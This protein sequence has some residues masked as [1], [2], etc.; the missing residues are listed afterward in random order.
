VIATLKPGVD[1]DR[2]QAEL[3]VIAGQMASVVPPRSDAATNRG[4]ALVPLSEAR[5]NASAVRA[6]TYVA[7]GAIFVL[8][9]AG[10]NLA[11]LVSARV[12]S[13]QREFGVRLAVGAGRVQVART[14]AVEMAF[15]AAGGFAL[16]VLLSAWTRDLVAWMIPG[17]IAAPSNDYGQLASFTGLDIDGSVVILAGVL[18]LL[19]MA[20][21]SLVAAWPAMRS[22]VLKSLRS[23]G[24]RAATRGPGVAE[25]ALLVVQV[26][27]SL[28]LVASAGLVL[29]SVTL[30]DNVDPGF[31]PERMIAFS[32]AED[33]AVQRPDVG[34]AL[35]D[36]LL[37]GLAAVPGVESVSA[38][39][40][41]P[42][43]SRCARLAFSI[44]GRPETVAEPLV[45]GWHRVGPDH[46][47]A[48]GIPVIRGRGFTADDRR[49]RAPVV[50]LNEAAAARFFPN[51][52]PIGRRITLPEVIDGDPQVAEIVAIVGDVIYWPPDEA[53]GPDVYQPALQFSHPYTT[54]MV[55]VTPERWRSATLSGDSGQPMFDSLRRA[56]TQL[57]ADL[58]MFDLVALSDLARAGRADRRFVSR[59]LAVCALLALGLAAVGIYSITA[60]AFQR[61]R[62]DMGLRIALGARPGQL[63]V[64]SMTSALTQAGLGVLAGL[65]LAVAAGRA[66]RAIL[67]EVGPN[68][69]AALAISAAVMLVVAIIAAWLPARRALRIDP[70]EQLRAD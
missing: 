1:R 31:N 25:R 37:A 4:A 59:L 45:T 61:R 23:G 10:V 65:V 14:V 67:F 19:T 11:S 27:A 46:F 49:G 53:P 26:A 54:V 68:D 22:D 3:N 2:A 15:V 60:S 62:K 5:T 41:T 43:G 57:D 58:P 17:G 66:L 33:L 30:L 48:L 16:A 70:V 56:V 9:I 18:G 20:A 28:S 47:R 55:R 12:A 50:A 44:E 24:D 64:A 42:F 35:V 32:V 36:R 21:A 7:A 51:Q 39:Q 6:R 52:N 40:C 8:L 38:G 63:V 29:K 69:P 34:P 13:R